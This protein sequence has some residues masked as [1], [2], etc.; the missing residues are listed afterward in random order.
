[1]PT[2]LLVIAAL[3]WLL[4]L[5][6]AFYRRRFAALLIW[7]LVAPAVTY[8]VQGSP[9]AVVFETEGIKMAP[10]AEFYYQQPATITWQKLLAPNRIV[11]SAFI[12]IFFF[13][14]VVKRQRSISI[15]AT[16]RWMILFS[17]ILLVN[18]FLWSARRAY[19]LHVAVDAFIVPFFAYYVARRLVRNEDR[20]RQ[21]TRI[22]GYMGLYVIVW[23]LIERVT[24]PELN[25][26]LQGPFEI[27]DVLYV[28]MAVVFFVTLLD[29]LSNGDPSEVKQALPRWV[30][31][32]VMFLAP[33]VILLTMT[34]GHW[35]AFPAGMFVLVLL[36]RRLISFSQQAGTIAVTLIL[37][38]VLVIALLLAVPEE[39][40][41]TRVADPSN[42]LGRFATWIAAIHVALEA[43]LLGVGLNNLHGLLGTTTM[44]FG[45][46]ENYNTPHNSLLSILAELGVV[47]LGAYLGIVGSIIRSGLYLYR[48]GKD[49]RDLWR[50]ITVAA[51]FVAYQVPS[52]FANT[53]YITGLI[54]LY[55]YVVMGAIVGLYSSPRSA[56]KLYRCD[57]AVVRRGPSRAGISWN[58]RMGHS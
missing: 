56:A 29:L 37:L 38:P 35:V 13:D 44:R 27:R 43:P 54:H 26:R 23:S 8:F 15:D 49:S 21:L 40:F 16:E 10:Q 45:G 1:M 17:L 14:G 36:G 9:E 24:V 3:P 25:Y 5:L 22:I 18:V 32:F 58:P 57:G 2:T 55:V 31:W 20:F 12:L 52:L 19:G 53:I 51:I 47:G 28:V 33:L 41:E 34:R 6:Y 50:G 42:V 4:I 11:F 46:F 30:R 39:F 7:L 48:N